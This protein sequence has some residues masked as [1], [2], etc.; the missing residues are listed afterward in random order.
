M[1]SIRLRILSEPWSILSHC[2][3]ICSLPTL[4]HINSSQEYH[5][6]LPLQ[7]RLVFSAMSNVSIPKVPECG[8]LPAV[9]M[10]MRTSRI[11]LE[12]TTVIVNVSLTT[13][14]SM[15]LSRSKM[16]DLRTLQSDVIPE[17]IHSL[18]DTQGEHPNSN[19]IPSIELPQAQNVS[20]H[21]HSSWPISIP[22][23]QR[24]GQVDPQAL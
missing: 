12:S 8:E 21:S 4:S 1:V 16:F 11:C 23:N 10:G 9:L 24:V 6:S 2:T 19:R 5:R 22:L 17:F 20:R 18:Q 13:E 15:A 3:W 14:L 7:F